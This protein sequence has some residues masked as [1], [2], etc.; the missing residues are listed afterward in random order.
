MFDPSP[1]GD[2]SL[3]SSGAVLHDLGAQARLE[4][5]SIL[6]DQ[7]LAA[8]S[9]HHMPSLRDAK[10][11]KDCEETRQARNI[12]L[13]NHRGAETLYTGAASIVR[14]LLLGHPPSAAT[15]ASPLSLLSLS[16]SLSAQQEL[17][18][19]KP[20]SMRSKERSR[21]VPSKHGRHWKS[22]LHF[23]AAAGRPS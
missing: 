1:P 15:T 22:E 17:Q 11:T 23:P 3:L 20:L 14:S 10:G 13:N 21:V 9:R 4:S 8:R 2:N 16:L 7:Q 19:V 18:Q 6:R 12:V 5:V